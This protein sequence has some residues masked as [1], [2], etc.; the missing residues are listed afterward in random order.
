MIFDFL[1]N[2]YLHNKCSDETFYLQLKYVEKETRHILNNNTISMIESINQLEKCDNQELCTKVNQIISKME[3]GLVSQNIK[4]LNS[5]L[6]VTAEKED[7]IDNFK[8][9]FATQLIF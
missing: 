7:V 8:M 3:T 1:Q 9:L 5:I 2:Q 4:E 6:S